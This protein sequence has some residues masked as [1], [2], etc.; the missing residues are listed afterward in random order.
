MEKINT[1]IIGLGNRGYSILKS[2][3]LRIDLVNVT[4]VCDV[5]QDRVDRAR[6]IV[7]ERAG[8]AP[9]GTT[10]A[11]EAIARPDVD[12][13][14][15]TAGWEAHV[16]L[17]V[18]C[19][20]AGKPCGFEVG[21]AYA[22]DDCFELVRVHEETGVPVMM[23]ENCCYNAEELAVTAM[24]RDGLF[25]RLVHCSGSYG[26]DLRYEI[27]FGDINRH[28]RLRNYMNRNCENYPTHELGPL[29]KILNIGRGNRMVSLVSLSSDSFGMAEY[30]ESR[31]ELAYLRGKKWA[32][33]DIFHTLIKCE[34]GESIMLKLD[35]TLPRF[36]SR[37]LQIRGTRG[38]YDMNSDIVYI[39]GDAEKEYWTPHLS[40]GAY[41]GSM[42]A[43][44][45]DKYLPR[46]W[47]DITPEEKK[48]GHGGMDYLIYR[49]F[50]RALANGTELPLDVYD[51]AA[52]MSVTC[53]SA[54]SIEEGRVIEIPDFTHGLYKTRPSRDVTEL[55]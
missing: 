45:F 54:Q 11:H 31:E 43:K 38:L 8:Y 2:V 27:G 15:I 7:V 18:E 24:V 29:A 25:G 51:A 16:P 21:G 28:Y 48:A 17:A 41:A 12:A 1:A 13:V 47:K 23:M 42:H 22:V 55:C 19:M 39:D 37:E 26:H 49:D 10:D 9:Y 30:T 50:F 40:V 4:V 52:W 44:Y 53:L 36:Y 14:I 34:N 46:L 3:L 35:T 6:N 20:K 33:G 32:Q 5:Y